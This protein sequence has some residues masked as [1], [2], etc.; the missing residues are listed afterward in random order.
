MPAEKR[1]DEKEDAGI[2]IPGACRRFAGARAD[3]P[4][5]LVSALSNSEKHD[6]AVWRWA[7]L[8]VIALR[9]LNFVRINVAPA[10]PRAR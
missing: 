8:S 4:R 9:M 2:S 3:D 1:A 7:S 6:T 5:S 10:C